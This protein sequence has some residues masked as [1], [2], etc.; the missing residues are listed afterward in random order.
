[1]KYRFYILLF[2]FNMLL[3]HEIYKEI[4]V[5]NDSYSDRS[6]FTSLDVHIDHATVTD[7]Y[8]QFVISDYDIQKLNADNLSYDIIHQNVEEFYQSRLVENYSYRDFDYGSMGGYYTHQE[9]IDHLEELVNEYPNLV[10]SLHVIGQSLEGRDIY[11]VKLSDNPNIDE[12]EPKV[13]QDSIRI[14]DR[15][16]LILADRGWAISKFTS[17][18]SHH[19]RRNVLKTFKDK[20]IDAI[21]AIKVLDEGFDVPMCNEAYFTASSTS[22]RQWVQRRGR[23]LRTSD[24]KEQQT[25]GNT[26]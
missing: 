9:I 26:R 18:E 8:I 6:Y 22:E 21:A 11:A 16:T 25:T 20:H 2:L 23:I 3:S 7:E 14:I 17:E 19:E 4:R 24:N 1:M 12:D 15:I 13:E 10:S 5:Y